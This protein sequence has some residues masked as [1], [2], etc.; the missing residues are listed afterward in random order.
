MFMMIIKRTIL[1]AIG[2]PVIELKFCLNVIFASN[3]Y[4]KRTIHPKL[5]TTDVSGEVTWAQ[6]TPNLEARGSPVSLDQN[7]DSFLQHLCKAGDYLIQ[8]QSM[9]PPTTREPQ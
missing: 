4:K 5:V 6:D 3:L 2:V 8:N 1:E 7:S 9:T